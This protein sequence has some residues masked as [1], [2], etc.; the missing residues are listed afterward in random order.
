MGSIVQRRTKDGG[1]TFLARV[2]RRGAKTVTASFARKTDAK[3]WLLETESGL[4]DGRYCE[5]SEDRKHT[6]AEAIDRYLLDY[7]SDVIRRNHLELWKKEIGYLLM[8]AVSPVVISDTLAKWKREPNRRGER[9][10][11]S[12][13]NRYI[14]SLSVFFTTAWREWGWAHRN[15]VREVRRLKEPRGRVRY[16]SD[17]ERKR[18]LAAC[19]T[20]YCPFIKLVVVLAL[21][22][23][24]RK[25]EIRYLRWSDVDIDQGF[26][27]LQK[28][29]NNE[30]RRVAVCGL[31]LQLLRQS[32]KVRRIDTDFLF[33]GTKS[34]K[35]NE[36][37]EITKAWYDV[38]L[39]SGLNDFVFHD[40]RHS[41]ASYLAMN[42]ATPLEI[43]EVLGHKSL[44]MVK[45]YSHLAESHVAGV[46]E[47]MNQKIFG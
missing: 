11:N 45:R 22:T 31:A 29:K 18:L 9:R 13:L 43:A 35:N 15:P 2:R 3:R 30:R 37:I 39:R 24:M 7:P 25:S 27:I 1:S 23:G 17:D 6:L 19:E 8:S 44:D 14:S 12:C 21:S 5:Q 46:V 42:G 10:G 26:I 38:R 20:S 33:P 4:V 28:T 36:P 41:A 40:L 34:A 47:R 32:S 16:L